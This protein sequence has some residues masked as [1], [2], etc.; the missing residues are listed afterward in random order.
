MNKIRVKPT[1]T[2]LL[3]TVI[4]FSCGIGP[5]YDPELRAEKSGLRLNERNV[6]V[7][8]FYKAQ[9]ELS[10]L[11]DL[12]ISRILESA[13][14]YDISFDLARYLSGENISAVAMKESSVNDLSQGEVM[15]SGSIIT[16]SISMDENFPIPGMLVVLLIG[17][18]LPSPIAFISGLDIM[19]QYDLTDSSGRILQSVEK[20][21]RIYYKDYYVWGRLFN[22][23]KHEEKLK[24]SV[25]LQIYDLITED[26]FR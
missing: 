4:A 24:E 5:I 7:T 16:K 25:E 8:N 2:F 3:F 22:Y 14:L 19:Y 15:L 13:K 12:E 1:L 10:Y 23:K 20:R 9:T 6:I 21:S 17:N 11:G 18:I 26:L